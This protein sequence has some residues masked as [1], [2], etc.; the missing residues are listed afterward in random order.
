MSR[1]IRL[2]VVGAGSI[3]G[4]AGGSSEMVIE[5]GSISSAE[6]TFTTGASWT[7]SVAR[8]ATLAAG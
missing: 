7:G 6:A 5:N 2:A 8:I 4:G 1:S 3:I